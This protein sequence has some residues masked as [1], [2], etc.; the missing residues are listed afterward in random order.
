MRLISISIALVVALWV[1]GCGSSGSSLTPGTSTIA[2]STPGPSVVVAKLFLGVNS[3][4]VPATIRL[5]ALSGQLLAQARTNGG[6]YAFFRNQSFP[7]DM[8]AVAR[9]EGEG[10]EF[11]AELRGFTGERQALINVPTTLASRY[12]RSHPELTLPQAEERIRLALALPASLSLGF[13]IAEGPGGYF[14]HIA[15]FHDAKQRGGLEA[16]LQHALRL[17]EQGQGTPILLRGSDLANPLTGLGSVSL[18]QVANLARRTVQNRMAAVAG[19]SPQTLRRGEILIEGPASLAGQFLLGVGTGVVGNVATAGIKAVF[20]WASNQ[21]GLNYGTGSQLAEILSTLDDVQAA[22]NSLTTTIND[23]NLQN[24]LQTLDNQL[25]PIVTANTQLQTSLVG[26][27]ITNQPFSPPQSYSTLISQLTSPQYPTILGQVQGE[28]VGPT[29]AI[30]TAQGLALNQQQGVDTPANM[31]SFPFRSDAKL[32]QLLGVFNKYSLL[33]VEAMNLYSEQAHNYQVHPNPVTG[34]RD[35]AADFIQATASLKAQRQQQAFLLNNNFIVDLENGVMWLGWL[36]EPMDYDTAVRIASSSSYQLLLP[37]GTSI[38]YDDW[39]LPT[40]GEIDSL[41]NRGIYCPNYDTT[42]PNPKGSP[43]PYPNQNMA[44][45]G[46]PGLGFDNISLNFTSENTQTGSANG[47]NGNVWLNYWEI[48]YDLTL[49]EWDAPNSKS[50]QEYRMNQGDDSVY[51]ESSSQ[52]NCFLVCRSIGTNPVVSPYA[53]IGIEGSGPPATGPPPTP[54]PIVGTALAPGE[55]AMYG[56]PTSINSISWAPAQ[57]ISSPI[58]VPVPTGAMQLAANVTYQVNLGGTYTIG[59]GSGATVTVNNPTQSYNATV[60][61][62]SA[63]TSHPNLFGELIAWS[64][65]NLEGLF[66]YNLPYL[67]GVA[68][69]YSATAVN[70]TASL[71]GA[72]GQA[73]TFSQAMTPDAVAPHTLQSIQISPRNQIYGLTVGQPA[74]GSYTYFCTGFYQDQSLASLGQNVTWS[75][76]PFPN[77]A[78]ANVT[79]TGGGPTLIL[80][81]PSQASSVPY[82]LTITATINQ[83]IVDSTTIQVVPPVAAPSPSPVAQAPTLVSVSPAAGPATGGTVVTLRGTNLGT[84]TRVTFAGVDAQFTVNTNDQVTVT[85]PPGSAGTVPI[86]LTTPAGTATATFTYQ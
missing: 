32:S 46:L 63:A 52:L 82:N 10:L 22:I 11:A 39:R 34:V 24:Q 77:P 70:I 57:P 74:S 71:L 12:L 36:E 41:R 16:W 14:S 62:L 19:Q 84:T 40:F 59:Y 83:T 73:V 50:A 61:T 78:G 23:Q 5:E 20:G 9:L 17:A 43:Q 4:P 81:Q 37:D 56:V 75:V 35:L 65:S 15:C 33:Q 26:A 67:S 69:P 64:S 1:G 45:S 13:G 49:G 30:M 79:Q 21:L 47:S 72:G 42:V 29:K 54:S 31:L 3:L 80:N 2:L 8:R 76:S 58:P 86:A 66:V 7:Q 85:T 38:T 44:T 27:T 55:L 60:S 25:V 68:I 28:L 18:D 51:G 48:N 53:S 6:G